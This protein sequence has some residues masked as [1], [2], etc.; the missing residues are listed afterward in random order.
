MR[1][2]LA[3]SLLCVVF[4]SASAVSSEA[5]AA[6]VRPS[7]REFATARA[8]EPGNPLQLRASDL[9]ITTTEG[10][11]TCEDARMPGTLQNNGLSSDNFLVSDAT[12]KASGGGPCASTTP[13]GSVKITA[14]PPKGGW[15]GLAR[16]S[17]GKVKII[18]PIALNATF[19]P[20]SHP[21]VSC[22]WS[23]T[24]VKATFNVDSQP[25]VVRVLGA[26]FKRSGGEIACPK[27]IRMSADYNLT[28]KEQG[29]TKQVAVSVS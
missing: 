8:L 24:K 3:V 25:I 6:R 18:G 1:F 9:V 14:S 16:T 4:S 19:E 13:L 5:F 23:A 2:K 28:T 11:I 15:P 26:K 20:P 12:F 21:T 7:F 22:I 10:N 17:S 29:G 27:T